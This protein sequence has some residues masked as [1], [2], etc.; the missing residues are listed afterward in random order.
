MTLARELRQC[1]SIIQYRYLLQL[2]HASQTRHW[3][4]TVA[5]GCAIAI[6][7]DEVQRRLQTFS[8]GNLEK[9]NE[10]LSAAVYRLRYRM[11]QRH[12]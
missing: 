10:L 12:E 8:I 3:I 9:L 7:L 4:D 5:G 1:P 2:H 6:V 11:R